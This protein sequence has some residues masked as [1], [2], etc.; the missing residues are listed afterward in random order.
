ML[1][2]HI[3]HTIAL[4]P[5]P[6]PGTVKKAGFVFLTSTVQELVESVGSEPFGRHLQI[7]SGLSICAR[8][9]IV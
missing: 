4:P 9:W 2:I 7:S 5:P 3:F 6:P 8:F 1:L